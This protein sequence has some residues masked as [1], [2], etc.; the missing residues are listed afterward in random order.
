MRFFTDNFF[1]EEQKSK[2]LGSAY[3]NYL[4]EQQRE[5]QLETVRQFRQREVELGNIQRQKKQQEF[6]RVIRLIGFSALAFIILL[7]I[8][9]SG[10][11]TSIIA[12]SI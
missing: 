9:T 6:D 1:T 7:V 5:K 8:L 4:K 12:G 3:G 2:M 11:N 10:L